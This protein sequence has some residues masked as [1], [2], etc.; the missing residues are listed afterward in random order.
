MKARLVIG[1][2]FL[3]LVFV[4][5]RLRTNVE[6]VPEAEEASSSEVS[7]VEFAGADTEFVTT[8]ADRGGERLAMNVDQSAGFVF[9]SEIDILSGEGGHD[10]VLRQWKGALSPS[11]RTLSVGDT[12]QLKIPGEKE[13]LIEVSSFKEFGENKGVVTG[14]LQGSQFGEA[15]FSYVNDAMAGSIRDPESDVYFEIWNAGNQQ[16]YFAKIDVAAQGHCGVCSPDPSSRSEK[17]GI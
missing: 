6:V 15:H 3:L 9:E 5:L 1:I 14:R 2:G 11:V 7:L 10:H 12:F 8:V 13:F 17:N 4:T 16:Q